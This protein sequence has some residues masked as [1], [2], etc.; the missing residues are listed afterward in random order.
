MNGENVL[1]KILGITLI[2]VQSFLIG[3]GIYGLVNYLSN[4]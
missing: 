4:Q 2:A 1:L 3:F